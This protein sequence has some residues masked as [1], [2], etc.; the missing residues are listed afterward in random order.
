MAGPN[1]F[2]EQCYPR[3]DGPPACRPASEDAVGT[4]LD[5][6]WFQ[7]CEPSG[8]GAPLCR[9]VDSSGAIEGVEATPEEITETITTGVLERIEPIIADPSGWLQEN[10]FH[11]EILTPILLQLSAIIV[12][13]FLA[14]LLKRPV[15][16]LAE[17]VASRAPETS[18]GQA[19]QTA[20]GLVTPAIFAALLYIA[21]TALAGLDYDSTLVRLSSALALAWL[22]IRFVTSFFPRQISRPMGWLIWLF[23]LFYAAGVLEEVMTWLNGIGPS[24][25][26]RTI[27]P[28]FVVQAILTAAVFLF[29]A[30]WLAK[31][32]K[33]RVGTLPKV[34]PSL[35][36]L[37]GNAIQIGLFFAAA[38]LTLAGLSIPLSGLAFLGGAIGFGIGFG[39]QKI[40]SN[41]ISGVILLSERSIK[42]NDVIEVDGTFG[43]VNSLG[44]RYASM[45]TQ[46][47]KEYLI[48][49]ELLITDKVINWSFSSKR[50][51]VHKRLRID[52]TS[53]L[54]EA[55]AIVIAAAQETPRVLN[56]P[57]PNCLVMEF[58]DEAIEL[59]VR[60]W[61]SD[62]EN[63]TANVASDILRTVWKKFVENGM[64]V[65]LRRKEVLIEPDSTLR[66]QMVDPDAPSPPV[67]PVFKSDEPAED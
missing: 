43:S 35:R 8:T 2:Y 28:P 15:K 29:G 51:R 14:F 48:P 24:F 40:I 1:D 37:L 18:R 53:D 33:T 3:V 36:I 67:A 9:R 27:S 13:M 66:V 46:D 22:L 5:K 38:V 44:L 47:G 41:F 11:T 6:S 34:E 16:R 4:T 31:K 20:T 25:G 64:S 49:N 65:P 61:I 42:P 63:G 39:M 23:A 45:V 12:C 30:N 62:P 21:Q 19:T 32:M 55:I 56:A 10:F 59:E 58:G 50:V 52:Y 17:M 57:R 7:I 60:F 54:E 26:G